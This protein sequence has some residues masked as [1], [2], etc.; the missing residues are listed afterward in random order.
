MA[1][2]AVP[3][4]RPGDCHR[5]QESRPL[6]PGPAIE[7]GRPPGTLADPWGM[8]EPLSD[9]AREVLHAIIREHISSG[10][11]GGSQT[12]LRS[13]GFDVSSATL[14]NVMP[15]LEGLGS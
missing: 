10:E 11:A 13:S 8:A 5:S 2:S 9:R 6:G 14:R 3:E 12:L 4:P 7:T 1:D 15:D